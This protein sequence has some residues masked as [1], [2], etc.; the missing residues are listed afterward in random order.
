MPAP[1]VPL[2]AEWLAQG[3]MDLHAVEILLGQNG[4]LPVVAFHLQ[5]TAEK[6]L[7]GYLLS[8]GW[9]LRRIH[10][11]EVLI[12][13]AMARDAEFAPFLAP[14]QRITEYYV[15][16]R[17]PTGISTKF[18]RE[19]LEADLATARA[20]VALIHGKLAPQE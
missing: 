12:Q 9:S 14:C 6:Y 1:E 19:A 13:E 16:T 8:R 7:K 15:E 2:P 10:D 11:L 5:Q 17:Y 3:D 4:P 20:L 18:L